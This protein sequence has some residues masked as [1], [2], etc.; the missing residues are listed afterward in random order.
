M[1]WNAP[2]QVNPKGSQPWKTL[3]EYKLNESAVNYDLFKVLQS[4]NSSSAI[5]SITRYVNG[6]AIKDRLTLRFN[7]LRFILD[8]IHSPR[9][10]KYGKEVFMRVL[11]TGVRFQ[12]TTKKYF[13][14]QVNNKK[15]SMLDFNYSKLK[16]LETALGQA[17]LVMNIRNELKVDSEELAS[18]ATVMILDFMVNY[19]IEE[20]NC[21]GL[22]CASQR[23]YGSLEG[24][25][26]KDLP[27]CYD[28][29]ITGII[30]D[31]SALT[32]AFAHFK[33]VLAEPDQ[34]FELCEDEEFLVSLMVDC[35]CKRKCSE[36]LEAEK[37]I[38]KDFT[39]FLYNN[40]MI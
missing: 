38:P 23:E 18:K 22:C 16:E 39:A 13:I 15:P 33:A 32:R 5:L 27:K 19:A 29:I 1:S 25:S 2:S 37:V 14:K 26:L 9:E 35:V 6:E 34:T 24:L 31:R 12:K 21:I 10:E 28:N 40:A 20:E 11:F 4:P 7:E 17:W 3:V 8:K 36:E 30:T